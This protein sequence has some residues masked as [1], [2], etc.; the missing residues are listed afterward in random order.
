L[1]HWFPAWLSVKCAAHDCN[2]HCIA[3][4]T[5]AVTRAHERTIH[6]ISRQSRYCC[7]RASDNSW[8]C[9]SGTG[10]DLVSDPAA[11]LLQRAR[12]TS[13]MA[14]AAEPCSTQDTRLHRLIY[15]LFII[16]SLNWGRGPYSRLTCVTAV[17]GTRTQR[18]QARAEHL[19]ILDD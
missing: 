1:V 5:P 10:P 13:C 6:T 19:D 15:L 2:E 11:H 14:K 3:L 18:S 7:F 9:G 4:H 17:G 12:P 8:Q 16:A